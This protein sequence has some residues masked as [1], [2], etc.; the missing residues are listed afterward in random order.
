MDH[1]GSSTVSVRSGHPRVVAGDKRSGHWRHALTMNACH[2]FMK[3]RVD[4][5]RYVPTTIAD[6][7]D[8]QAK[9]ILDFYT[10]VPSNLDEFFVPEAQRLYRADQG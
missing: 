1:A 7:L 5:V 3:Q 4:S 8:E 9:C 6:S 2:W 10:R